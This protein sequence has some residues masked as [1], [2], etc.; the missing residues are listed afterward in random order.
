MSKEMVT[1][2]FYPAFFV[3]R[4]HDVRRKGE[5]CAVDFTLGLLEF[6]GSSH[7]RRRNTRRV[8]YYF[9]VVQ[10]FSKLIT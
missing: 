7:W 2:E 6:L 5:G 1:P 3:W 9:S 8:R 4:E 10:G